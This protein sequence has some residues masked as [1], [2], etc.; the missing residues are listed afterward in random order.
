MSKDN[1]E[2]FQ[3][4]ASDFSSARNLVEVA[5]DV[6]VDTVTSDVLTKINK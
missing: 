3:S 1:Q 2:S 4:S 6:F 5:V